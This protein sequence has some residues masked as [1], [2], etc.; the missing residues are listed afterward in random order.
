MYLVFRFLF[1]AVGDTALTLLLLSLSCCA[2]GVFSPQ[3]R[4]EFEP[5]SSNVG[6]VVDNMALGQ[7]FSEYFSFLC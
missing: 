5:G 3:W 4:P 1:A 6:F 2:S 7:V